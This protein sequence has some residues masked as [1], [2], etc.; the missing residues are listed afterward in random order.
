MTDDSARPAAQTA[1]LAPAVAALW[2]RQGLTL[3]A[4]PCVAESYDL[5]LEVAQTLQAMC[6]AQGV[7]YIFKASF[8]KANRTSHTGYRGQGMAAGL[9]ILARVRAEL[10]VPVITD[11]HAPE[12]AAPVA[13]VADVLQIP[14][15][16]CR[17]TDLLA[18]AAATGRPVSIKKGQFLAPDD[19]L[20]VARKFFSFGGTQVALTERGTT[21][22]YHNLVVDM[23]GLVQM[24]AMHVGPVIFDATHAVQAPGAGA[25]CSAGDRTLAP[26]L[27]RAAVAVGVDGL[28]CEV[29]P[30]P[31]RALSD[32]PNSLNFPMMEKLLAQ[33]VAIGRALG[34][35]QDQTPPPA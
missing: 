14:A 5:C 24:R 16:L 2:Q 32:G 31:D 11:I 15:L 21:F 3:I 35:L 12:Q 30:D 17:Q 28:F 18:A 33:V 22:G 25:G 1:P 26:P 8:D 27:A 20:H 6:R 13:E 34:P 23:R 19:M 9:D 7:H 10:N 4:G 29:H